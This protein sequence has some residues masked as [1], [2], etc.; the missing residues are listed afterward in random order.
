[1]DLP[2]VQVIGLQAVQRFVEHA[3]RQRLVAAMGTYLSHQEHAVAYSFQAGAHPVFGLAAVILPTIV[4]ESNASI[5]GLPDQA[6][7]SGL[8]GGVS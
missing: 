4:E 7:G 5:Y 6:Y 8:I 2:K 1:M 3:Q